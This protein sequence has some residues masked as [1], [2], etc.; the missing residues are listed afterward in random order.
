MPNAVTSS[1]AIKLLAAKISDG[2]R[3]IHLRNSLEITRQV[4]VHQSKGTQDRRFLAETPETLPD[5]KEWMIAADVICPSVLYQPA[6]ES[7]GCAC[8]TMV[9]KV[10]VSKASRAPAK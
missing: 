10:Q 6:P 8:R 9:N 2:N 3:I 4:S 5:H 1:E 7:V